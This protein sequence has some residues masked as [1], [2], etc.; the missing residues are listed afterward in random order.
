M[1]K[2]SQMAQNKRNRQQKTAK[3]QKTQWNSENS[4]MAKDNEL[5]RERTPKKMEN[6][7]G[8]CYEGGGVSRA[9]NVFFQKCFFCGKN[10]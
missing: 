9:I 2:S 3:W 4:P 5:V 1:A 10:I 6:F 8:I 7:N